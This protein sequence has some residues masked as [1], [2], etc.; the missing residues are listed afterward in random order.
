MT[1]KPRHTTTKKRH[2]APERLSK[3]L[4]EQRRLDLELRETLYKELDP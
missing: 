1:H 3:R 4:A 2:G